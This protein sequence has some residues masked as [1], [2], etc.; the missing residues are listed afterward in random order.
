[1]KQVKILYWENQNIW[2]QRSVIIEV[3]DDV[4]NKQILLFK[5]DELEASI[6]EWIDVESM[7]YGDVSE[8]QDIEICDNNWIP[9]EEQIISFEKDSDEK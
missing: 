6:V 8:I 9:I 1:M 7:D 4:S 3:N 5:Q 2:Q